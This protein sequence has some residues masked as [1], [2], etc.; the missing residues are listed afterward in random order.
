MKVIASGLPK[1]AL[2]MVVEAVNQGL[3]GFDV[4]IDQVGNEDLEFEVREAASRS[5]V[6]SVILDNS[7]ED[8]VKDSGKATLESDKYI[9][10]TDLESLATDLERIFPGIELEVPETIKMDV[11]EGAINEDQE[12][13]EN[14]R[15]VLE[16]EIRNLQAQIKELKLLNEFSNTSS[17]V[18]TGGVSQKSETEVELKSLISDLKSS[19]SSKETALKEAESELAKVREEH[20]KLSGVLRNNT[21]IVTDLSHK[22]KELEERLSEAE[23]KRTSCDQEISR[24]RE[25]VSSLQEAEGVLKADLVSAQ[26]K[27]AEVASQEEE[28]LSLKAEVQRE[29]EGFQSERKSLNQRIS[30]LESE[31]LEKESKFASL[32]SQLE[33]NGKDLLK[34]NKDILS[35]ENKIKAY[36]SEDLSPSAQ[37]REYLASLDR[38][39]E[40]KSNIFFRVGDGTYPKS[41]SEISVMG[42]SRVENVSLIAPSGGESVRT[43]YKFLNGRFSG[44]LEAGATSIFASFKEDKPVLLVDLNTESSV[45]YTF[46]I[47]NPVDG[48]DWVVRGGGVSKYLSNTLHK[49]VKVLYP[50]PQFFNEGVLLNVDWEKRLQ[51]LESSGYNVVVILGPLTS[52]VYRTLF[53]GFTKVG[54][55]A[56]ITLGSVINTRN[57][58]IATSQLHL[59][60][61][62]LVVTNTIKQSENYVKVL[63]KRFSAVQEVTV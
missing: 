20:S 46:Q 2:D 40:L 25:K 51:E 6:L 7:S 56:V 23:S 35:L 1:E 29:L 11:V 15:Y 60:G 16:G 4:L 45:D 13:T 30:D 63:E 3:S 17:G 33:S 28:S 62:D 22:N 19:L 43:L 48:T 32:N 38:I 41:M 31:L 8:R 61:T 55:T 47:N 53:E 44:S 36:E 50:G 27:L 57:A 5:D 49:S 34:A 54:S 26:S 59:E 21:R 58:I 24:L 9:C 42:L 37:R 10:Y 12:V 18:P 52:L 14:E 39:E